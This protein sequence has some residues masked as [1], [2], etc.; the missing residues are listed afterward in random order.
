M[1]EVVRRAGDVAAD[2]I[3]RLDRATQLDTVPEPEER[4]R[5]RAFLVVVI[6][7]FLSYLAL[8]LIVRSNRQLRIDI[9]TTIRFQVRQH[10][11]LARAMTMISWFGFRPQSLILPA[12]AVTVFSVRRSPL[13]GLF[14]GAAW[15]SSLISYTTKLFVQRPRPSNPLIR[16]AKANIR[17]TSF[18][19][20]HTLH[21]TTFWG[22]V[23]YLSLTHIKNRAVRWISAAIITPLILLVGPSRVYLGHHWLTDVLASYLLGSAYLISLIALYRRVRNVWS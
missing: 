10:P 23:L 13:D 8:L 17:D 9:A 3:E 22:F 14:L 19:S 15:A 11:L 21:Y 4:R 2:G 20:G 1:T 5:S 18:P 12:T 16:V 7:A 6:G